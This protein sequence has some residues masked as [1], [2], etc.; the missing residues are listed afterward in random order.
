MSAISI[1]MSAISTNY[2]SPASILCLYFAKITKYKG[3]G[4]NFAF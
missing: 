3:A 4:V 2:D 1:I